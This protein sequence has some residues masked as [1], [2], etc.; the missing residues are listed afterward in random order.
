MGSQPPSGHFDLDGTAAAYRRY[1]E[2][3]LFAPWAQKLVKVVGLLPDETV[4]DIAAG[5]GAVSRVAASAVGVGGRVIASDISAAMLHEISRNTDAA[6]APIATVQSSAAD[7]DLADASVDVAL[8]QQG[9]Q[10]MPDK[11]AVI[12]E[13][14]RV[15]R[16][17]G[18][19]G[20][21]VWSKGPWLSP[22]DD[23]E[24]FVSTHQIGGSI[25]N[26]LPREQF[27]M[28]PTEVASLLEAGGFSAVEARDVDLTVSWSSIEEESRGI[29]GS[30]FGRRMLLQPLDEQE[31]LIAE[32]AHE[33]GGEHVTTS[34]I[35]TAKKPE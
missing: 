29:L 15:L 23:Y 32:L 25:V 17:G 27:R 8:C 10:F 18:R 7:L 11:P 3:Y 6:A 13:M 35:A 22:L 21:A 2:P 30:P 19:V 28:L 16:P 5:T 4:L 34:V 9:L 24:Q 26:V 31:A 14:L 12:A 33:L 20:I 1:L